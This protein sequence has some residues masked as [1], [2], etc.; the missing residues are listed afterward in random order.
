MS[1]KYSVLFGILATVL[2]TTNAF[3]NQASTDY[4]KSAIDALRTEL[5]NQSSVRF[6]ELSSAT[7][8]LTAKTNELTTTLNQLSLQL[9]RFITQTND[10]DTGA[11]S[12]IEVVQKQVNE[13]PII[14]HRIG[15]VFQGGMVFYVDSSQQH[16]LMVSLNN[17]GDGVEWRN[18]EGGDRITNA[19]AQG[20][21]SGETNTRLIIAQ[22]TIDQQEGQFAALAAANYQISSDGKS[23]CSTTMNPTLTCYGG[24]YLPSLYEL[25]LLNSTLKHLGLGEIK[26][27]LYWSSTESDTTQAWLV[28]FASGEPQV[29]DKATPAHI[30][31]IHAF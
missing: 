13:L 19:Q 21:G 22:Q 28:D 29:R 14:T 26:E 24:W 17:L 27:E 12:K 11:N 16:G 9:N 31:A 5:S 30:R 20:L 18:G 7:K 2:C 6:N 10:R 23:P 8:Q 1:K 25:V 15:E 4:V 3:S